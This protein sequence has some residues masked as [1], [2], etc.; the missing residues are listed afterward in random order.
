MSTMR[1]SQLAD[2]A[3]VPASTLRY[4][5]SAGLLP[6]ERTPA[7]Y[8]SYGPDALERLGVIGA[9]KQ[10]GLP[11]DEIAELLEVW[12]SGTCGQVRAD[13][14]PRV[15]TRLTQAEARTAELAALTASLRRALD[16]LDALPDRA[17]RCDAQCGF[18]DP[19]PM[20]VPVATHTSAK[21]WRS[22][23]V[24]C[25]LTSAELAE[26]ADQW[27]TTLTGAVRDTIPDGVRLTLPAERVGLLATLA[28]AEQHCCP[29]FDFRLHLDG[30][31]VHL[32]ARAPAAAADLLDR[33]FDPTQD[34]RGAPR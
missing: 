2:Q 27:R 16:H 15:A 21:R 19:R 11:L 9:A 12:E 30:P 23:P 32:E 5:E 24:A 22:A 10:L 18:P 28:A 34:S 8:R 26:R 31:V 13:L 33:L 7:G 29:F 20:A 3:G 17:G 4:Y 14:R 6:A 1:I 25:T